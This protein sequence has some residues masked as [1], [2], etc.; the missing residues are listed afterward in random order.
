MARALGDT[1]RPCTLAAVTT[2]LGF[3]SL[4]AADMVPVREVGLIAAAGILVS[5]MVN[6][7]VI[8]TL[9]R[10][11]RIPA[12]SA[13]VPGWLTRAGFDRPWAVLTGGIVLGLAGLLSLPWL[14]VESNPLTFLPRSSATVEDYRE[15]SREL[16]GSYTME[17]IL[18]TP[19]P[20]IEPAVARVIAGI[21]H[22]IEEEPIVPVV[23]SP[24]DLLRKAR[25]WHAGFDPDEYR[26][27]ETFEESVALVEGLGADGTR[28]LRR[29][30]TTDGRRVRL[31]A[32]VN[33]MDQH[34]FLE[35]VQ[36]TEVEL[37]G[38]PEG[39]SGWVTGMVLR[40]VEAQRDLVSTQIRSLGLAVLVVFSAI[41]LGLR[42]LRLSL[43][44]AVPNLVPIVAVFGIMS[45][46][47]IPLDAATVMVASVALGI[48]VDNTVHLLVA[49]ERARTSGRT[50]RQGGSEAVAVVG[51]AM[52]VT[53]ATAAAGFFSLCLSAFIPIRD[54]GLLAGSAMVLALLA[55][56][57]VVPAMLS[58][59]GAR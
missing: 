33:E 49:Y 55:D 4:A 57:Y 59:G 13:A 47:G 12:R 34:R 37:A 51:V 28:T 3:A 31:S 21:E 20:W 46:T 41:A 15:V 58:L 44:S 5:L 40:L 52:V 9:A 22:H 43:L 32:V 17:V 24:L 39:F 23:L 19:E 53:T 1:T 42:S 30:A 11:A 29:L 6:L 36:H 25:Q 8:P 18:S 54:F 7:T 16:T 38:L 56:L 48:A 2:A 14:R 35:L 10:W 27:P 45:V 26:L 50:R